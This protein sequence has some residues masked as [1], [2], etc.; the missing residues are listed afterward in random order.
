MRLLIL[1]FNLNLHLAI[2]NTQNLFT[3][4]QFPFMQRAIAGGVLMGLLGGLLGSF[5]T[6]YVNYRFLVMPSVMRL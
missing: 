3:L 5:V 2:T 4:L 1:M 6:L